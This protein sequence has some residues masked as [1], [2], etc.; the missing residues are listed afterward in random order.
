MT[1][2]A[3]FLISTLALAG[4]VAIPQTET[5]SVGGSPEVL[6]Y[7][8][9]KTAI[10]AT[11][12]NFFRL[13]QPTQVVKAVP[14]RYPAA[15]RRLGVEGSVIVEVTVDERG[16]VINASTIGEP[17]ELLADAAVSA[18]RQWEFR[19][20]TENGLTTKVRFRQP[21]RFKLDPP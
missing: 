1:K 2:L 10:T 14:P 17:N 7:E 20:H 21:V 3:L 15:A 11:S 5:Y 4:C 9:A 16:H 13:D 12:T 6:S 8:E 18:V 19:P